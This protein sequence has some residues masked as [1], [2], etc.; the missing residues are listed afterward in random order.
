MA[1]ATCGSRA[2]TRVCPPK[3]S[4]PTSVAACSPRASPKRRSC[5]EICIASSRVGATTRAFSPCARENRSTIGSANAA[6]FPVP[7]GAQPIRSF[8]SSTWGIA[9]AW[10]GVGVVNCSRA[11]VSSRWAESP[12]AANDGGGVV[13]TRA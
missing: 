13:D 1:T 7:V 6:V 4:P 9:S 3:S 8:P 5:S 12:S 11:S 2:S 10:I